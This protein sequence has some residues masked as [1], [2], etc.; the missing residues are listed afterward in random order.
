MGLWECL[1][2]NN[3]KLTKTVDYTFIRVNTILCADILLLTL[4]E[5]VFAVQKLYKQ[6]YY[7]SFSRDVITF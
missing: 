2:I 3:L 1:S 6:L 4:H 5:A 7:R